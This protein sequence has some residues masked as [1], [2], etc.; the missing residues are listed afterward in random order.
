MR[1]L[2]AVLWAALLFVPMAASAR[3]QAVIIT[4]QQV[5]LYADRSLLVADGGVSIRFAG[6]EIDATHAVY[7]LRANQ[8]TAAGHVTVKDPSG[9][10]QGSGYV[11]DFTKK[12]GRLLPDAHVPEFAAIDALATGQ[13]V[14]LVPAASITFSNA[15]VRSGTVFVPAATYTYDIPAPNAK[16]FGYSPVPSAAL[17]WPLIVSMGRNAYSFGRLRYDKYNG[18][19]GAGM[20]EHYAATGRGYVALGQ[21]LDVDGGRFDL[22]AYQ[23]INDSLSQSLTGSSLLGTHALRYAINASTSRGFA[24]LSFSQNNAQRSDDLYLTG[25]QRPVWGLGSS[26][27]QITF[28]HDVHPG[29]WHVAQDFRVTPA[30]HFDTATVH[31]ARWAVFGSFDVG[32]SLYDYG[33]ATLA[34]AAGIHTTIPVNTHLQLDGGVNFSHDAPPFPSTYR[35]FSGGFTWKASDAFNLVSSLTY[36]HDFGQSFGNGRPQFAAAFDLRVRRRNG[37]GV[38]IG[39]ILPFG[40][41]GDMNRQSVLNIR[42]LR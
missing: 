12:I 35:S 41:L 25:N 17:E 20:E 10:S 15:N 5:A 42:F 37:T 30:V 27:L 22:A 3:S 19:V 31:L 8:L 36:T 1:R 2:A 18:G 23:R 26:R 4:A 29:D 28:G 11:Y 16:D 7:D 9:R 33:R 38:E 24:S 21:T 32:E 6:L 40:G 13:Q 14:E 34:S 39:A